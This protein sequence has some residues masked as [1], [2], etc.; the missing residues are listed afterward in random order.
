MKDSELKNNSEISNSELEDVFGIPS[1]IY[2]TSIFLF[3]NV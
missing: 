3:M 1:S 2:F